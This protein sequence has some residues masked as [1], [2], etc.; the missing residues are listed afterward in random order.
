MVG[1]GLYFSRLSYERPLFK[2]KGS[3]I[4]AAR[5]SYAD[6]LAQPFLTNEL[7]GAKFYFYDLTAKGNYR[8]NDKNTVFL[9]GYLGRDVFGSDFGFNWGNTTVSAR[10][11][12][13]FSDRLFLNTTAYYSNY[14]YSLNTDLKQK[15][16]E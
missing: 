9:S 15:R 8:I 13:V 4:V 5:R 1:L 7:K 11:N 10:W 2:G 6:I 3:F 14:D 16:S 12:H